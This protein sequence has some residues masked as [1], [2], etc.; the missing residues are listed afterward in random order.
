MAKHKLLYI[1]LNDGSDT[2]INKQIVTLSLL[3]EIHFLGIGF[4]INN[5]FIKDHCY[6]CNI[7]VGNKKS[8]ISLLKYYLTFM[9]LYFTKSYK[10]IHIINEFPLSLFYLFL[11]FH[12]HVVLD[13]FDSIYL[14]KGDKWPFAKIIRYILY[15]L[16]KTIISTDENRKNMIPARFINKIAVIENFP[17]KYHGNIQK[18][19]PNDKISIYYNGSMSKVRGTQLLQKL[20]DRTDKV[21]INMAGWLYDDITCELSK[22]PRVKYHGIV[23][24]EQSTKLA[25]Q[26]DY[27]LCLYEPT[28]ENN[29]NASPNKIYDAIQSET[30]VIINKEVKVS[31]FVKENNLG[32]IIDNYYTENYDKIIIDLIEKKKDF[33]FSQTLKSKY[34]WESIER[35]FL[36]IHQK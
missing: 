25:S 17:Y 11:F 13:L 27:I 12:N 34:I 36:E 24:Q 18:I 6:T 29:I 22:Y 7:I 31:A 33:K 15:S 20:L 26:N 28:N 23:T 35:K 1:S 14:S 30:P 16:P 5:N 2:R 32:Y 10:S 8:I 4:S 3:F 19:T 21:I 9:K